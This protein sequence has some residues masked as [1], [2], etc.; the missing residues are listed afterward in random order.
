MRGMRTPTLTLNPLALYRQWAEVLTSNQFQTANSLL[1]L[2]SPE[3]C[4]ELKAADW[5]PTF[6]TT[7][8]MLVLRSTCSY[9]ALRAVTVSSFS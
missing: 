3:G 5:R 6:R 2:F 4:L 9:Y 1:T 8:N 7:L